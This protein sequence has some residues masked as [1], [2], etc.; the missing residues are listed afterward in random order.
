MSHQVNLHSSSISEDIYIIRSKN[1]IKDTTCCFLAISNFSGVSPKLGF[2]FLVALLLLIALH[3][4]KQIMNTNNITP[5][6]ETNDRIIFY[7]SMR[8]RKFEK[9]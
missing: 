6:M 3:T 8:Y 4:N 5:K 2:R 9:H 1:V 7:V